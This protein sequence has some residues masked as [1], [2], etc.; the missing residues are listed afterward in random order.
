MPN[1]PPERE[2]EAGPTNIGKV[3]DYNC[4]SHGPVLLQYLHWSW[5]YS[6]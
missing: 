2:V 4:P 5:Q 6:I 1:V 3:I